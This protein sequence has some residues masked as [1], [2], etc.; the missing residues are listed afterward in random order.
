[1]ARPPRWLNCPRKSAVLAGKELTKLCALVAAAA[2]NFCLGPFIVTNRKR[3]QRL[4]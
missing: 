2:E 1:M 4:G 3:P